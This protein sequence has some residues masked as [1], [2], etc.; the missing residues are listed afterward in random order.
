[1]KWINGLSEL[2]ST[3]MY[4]L[5]SFLNGFTYCTN[6]GRMDYLQAI[7]MKPNNDDFIPGDN[8]SF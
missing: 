5:D 3:T 8:F 1:M 6:N 7:Q 4:F 2:N